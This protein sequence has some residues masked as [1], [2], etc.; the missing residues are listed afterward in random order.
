MTIEHRLVSPNPTVAKHHDPP[1]EF[2]DVRLRLS[3][4]VSANV[5]EVNE[6]DAEHDQEQQ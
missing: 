5:Q 1:R 6:P 2:R 3:I 4:A